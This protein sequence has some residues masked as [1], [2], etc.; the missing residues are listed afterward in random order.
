MSIAIAQFVICWKFIFS[1]KIALKTGAGIVYAYAKRS[2]WTKS[3]PKG[4]DKTDNSKFFFPERQVV[5]KDNP[6]CIL[7]Y[8]A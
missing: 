2:R 8:K 7:I 6:P 3:F 1:A 5:N 4:R